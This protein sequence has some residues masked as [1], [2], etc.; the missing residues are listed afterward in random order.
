MSNVKNELFDLKCNLQELIQANKN[1]FEQ[2]TQRLDGI[3]Y[4]DNL[5]QKDKKSSDDQNKL[6]FFLHNSSISGCIAI[7]A[8]YKASQ[9]NDKTFK[10]E[11]LN[12][13]SIGPSQLYYFYGYIMA[14]SALGLLD[15]EVKED[16]TVFV[17]KCE[18]DGEQI[19]LLQNR[20]Q[21]YVS[22]DDASIKRILKYLG[23]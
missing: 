7:Y 1:G 3:N 18:L 13:D 20:L 2:V 11:D 23:F 8:C 4:N 5:R 15:V 12:V 21:E 14:A 16:N 22:S 19:K 17:R 10:L 9:K 6:L